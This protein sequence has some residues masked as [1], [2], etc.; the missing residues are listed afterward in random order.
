MVIDY[1][2][3]SIMGAT[4]A[5][6]GLGADGKENNDILAFSQIREHRDSVAIV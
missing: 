6:Q 5:R 4:D 3:R 1:A 2:Y